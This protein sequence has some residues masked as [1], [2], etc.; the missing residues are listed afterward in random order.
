MPMKPL[1]DHP[2]LTAAP[3][4]ALLIWTDGLS[5]FTQLPGPGGLPMVI[6]NP[7]TTP[8]LSSTLGL[9]R[10]RALD[11]SAQTYTPPEPA[12]QP[13]T[14]AQRENARDILRRRGMIG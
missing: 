13:G 11:C 9:I 7:L 6:R 12:N 4:N 5:I 8:G 2:A 14:H 3:P 10:T 1:L